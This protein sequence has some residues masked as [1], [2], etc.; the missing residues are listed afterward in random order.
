MKPPNF[1]EVFLLNNNYFLDF[2][3]FLIYDFRQKMGDA[4]EMTHDEMT[5]DYAADE[6]V[7]A[8]DSDQGDADGEIDSDHH[9]SDDDGEN[10][11]VCSDDGD[12]VASVLFDS[13]N[14]IESNCMDSHI[15]SKSHHDLVSYQK[16]RCMNSMSSTPIKQ[17]KS[18]SYLLLFIMY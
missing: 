14:N 8:A 17:S 1:L 7:A 4:G 13:S 6:M 9:D 2:I 18:F 10:A 11:T 3:T 12:G 15:Y 16:A 5:H